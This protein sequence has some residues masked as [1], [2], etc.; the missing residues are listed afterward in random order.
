LHPAR[1]LFA[2]INVLGGVA[3]LG[4]YALGIAAHPDTRGE[5]WGG[6]PQ[7]LRPLYT[8]SM[9]LAA[10]GYFAFSGFVW[11]R[12]DPERTRIA[13]RFGFGLLNAL[14]AL[15]LAPSALW[16][17]LTFEMLEAPSAGLWAAIRL[18]LAAVGLG[19]LGL[20]AALLAVRPREPAWAHALA[21]AGCA[22]FAVQTALLDALVW[23]AFFPR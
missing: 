6:V 2:A 15:I 16:M 19:S 4:S 14:Y 12:L 9:L 20:L 11:L 3:V 5:V 23:P 7:G 21:V 8:V 13:G 22:A 10:A 17:P 18:V 1:R